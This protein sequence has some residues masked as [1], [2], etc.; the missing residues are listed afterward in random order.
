MRTRCWRSCWPSGP[1]V[2]K[3]SNYADTDKTT[4]TRS[5][6]LWRLLT[7]VEGTFRRKKVLGCVYKPNSNYL[8]TWKHPYLKK[9]LRVRVVVDY[10]NMRFS[11]FAI[12]YLNKKEKIRKSFF[13]CSYGPRSDLLSKKWS[14]IS[15]HFPFKGTL[16]S[17]EISID[18]NG[19]I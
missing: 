8:E 16:H 17:Y 4:R 19:P 5:E 1:C 18:G 11:N 2:G 9:I 14:K 7:D 10:A 13:A 12:E 15:W 6:K 3:V